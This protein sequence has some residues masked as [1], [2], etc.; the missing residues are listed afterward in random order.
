MNLQQNLRISY[1]QLVRRYTSELPT[2]RKLRSFYESSKGKLR[3]LKDK[4]KNEVIFC[5]GNGPSLNDEQLDILNGKTVILTNK[6]FSLLDKFKPKDV[7]LVFTDYDRYVESYA[8]IP[9]PLK[10]N[11][12]CS[13][14][15][16]DSRVNT[17]YFKGT[18]FLMPKNELNISYSGKH[19]SRKVICDPGFTEDIAN[20][21]IYPSFS[22]IFT[23]IQ[24]ANYMGAKEIV[25]LG[26]DMNINKTPQSHFVRGVKNLMP[27]FDYFIHAKPSFILFKD[28]LAKKGIKLTNA[29]IRSM[30]DVLERKSLTDYR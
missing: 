6:A 2:Y 20:E 18:V 16:F 15:T 23:S 11:L 24:I 1:L 29:S 21:E 3:E 28:L 13:T 5:V 26:I 30:E 8:N 9:H 27:E 17:S 25:C 19:I 7:Y 22:V 14:N 12:I 10:K 4:H